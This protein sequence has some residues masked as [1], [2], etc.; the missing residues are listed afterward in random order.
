MML[1]LLGLSLVVVCSIPT[2][3]SGPLVQSSGKLKSL[4]ISGCYISKEMIDIPSSK[5]KVLAVT[6]LKIKKITNAK[7]K[8]YVIGNITGA[9]MNICSIQGENGPLQM[10]YKNNSLNYREAMEWKDNN[11]TV[12]RKCHLKIKFLKNKITTEDVGGDYNCTRYVFSC[13]NH[14]SLSDLTFSLSKKTKMKACNKMINKH[15]KK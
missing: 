4:N 6:W 10:E 8:Y 1:N 3:I 9:Y 13:G 2:V 12:K 11:K 5:K 14:V 15:S 7:N